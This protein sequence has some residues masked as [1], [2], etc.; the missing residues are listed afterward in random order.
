MKTYAPDLDCRSRMDAL[1][2]IAFDSKD[3]SLRFPAWH[4][5]FQSI[6]ARGQFLPPPCKRAE[7]DTWL[8]APIIVRFGRHFIR[9][10]E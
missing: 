3:Q 9:K 6:P 4:C 10:V 1:R 7:S 2:G 8:G 5:N